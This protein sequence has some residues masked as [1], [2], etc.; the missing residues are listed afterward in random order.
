MELPGLPRLCQ[1]ASRPSARPHCG[2]SLST[3]LIKIKI[4][5][6][7]SFIKTGG[8]YWWTFFYFY[9]NYNTWGHDEG[10]GGMPEVVNDGYVL[11]Q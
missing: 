5:K 2:K 3:I 10:L 11:C 6:L 7:S 1:A 8:W 4:D 9:A